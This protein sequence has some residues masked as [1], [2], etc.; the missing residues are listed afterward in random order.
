MFLEDFLW[1]VFNPH[2]GIKKFRKGEIWWHKTWWGP[3]P[4]LYWQMAVITTVLLYF[5][6]PAI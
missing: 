5:G 1:F 2:Y 6:Y 4:S 3:V